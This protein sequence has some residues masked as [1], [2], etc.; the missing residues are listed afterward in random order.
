M[1]VHLFETEDAEKYGVTAA[2]LLYNIRHWC[3]KNAAND[4]HYHEGQFWTYNSVKAFEELFP[5]LTAKQIRTALEKLEECGAIKTGNFNDSKYDRT[6][7]YSCQIDLPKKANGN[8]KQGNSHTYVNT[9]KNP[10]ARDACFERFWMSYPKK[11]GKDAAQRAWQKIKA[12]SDTL[13][14]ILHALTWQTRS[15][16]WMR[17]GGQYIPNP[18]TYLNQGR[19]KDERPAGIPERSS[20]FSGVL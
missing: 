19:W 18:A 14:A 16:Q 15:E 11:V 17:D 12:P 6:M 7:W 2:V 13:D 20:L 5:Y 1:A 3:E 8:A 10:T 9:D 4:K